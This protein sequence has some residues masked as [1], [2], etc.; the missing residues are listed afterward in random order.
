MVTTTTATM[1]TMAMVQVQVHK[2]SIIIRTPSHN[3]IMLNRTRH[4]SI[5]TA[6]LIMGITTQV[7]IIKVT[8]SRPIAMINTQMSTTTTMVETVPIIMITP[9]NKIIL[10]QTL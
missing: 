2:L 4:I 5:I 8:N 10:N 3:L 1:T 6:M 7:T 9:S